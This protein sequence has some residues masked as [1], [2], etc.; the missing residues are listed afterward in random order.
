MMKLNIDNKKK[1]NLTYA[2]IAVGLF[3]LIQNFLVG[4][5]ATE[6]LPYS[7]FL[8]LVETA[9]VTDVVV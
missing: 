2:L 3:L 4:Y 6:R 5:G 1:F 8:K 9:G 7:Q